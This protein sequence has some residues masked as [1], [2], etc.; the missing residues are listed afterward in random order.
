MCIGYGYHLH[1]SS[2]DHWVNLATL[3]SQSNT[4][5]VTSQPQKLAPIIA[6]LMSFSRSPD[7]RP[8]LRVAAQSRDRMQNSGDPACSAPRRTD[9]PPVALDGQFALTRFYT[10]QPGDVRV[11]SDRLVWLS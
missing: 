7:R 1:Y 11:S 3:S 6:R 8:S 4:V 2:A 10:L 5:V 9:S